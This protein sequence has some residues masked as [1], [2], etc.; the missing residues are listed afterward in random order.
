MPDATPPRSIGTPGRLLLWGGRVVGSDGEPEP[1]DIFIE[2]GHIAAMGEEVEAPES[3]SVDC[4]RCLIVPA[5]TDLH[6]HL[7]EPGQ[8][9]K[10]TVETGCLAAQ[11][12]GVGALVCMPNT[13]P[14]LA[15]P[16]DVEFVLERAAQ[17]G[18]GVHVMV[19]GSVL[20]YRGAAE[21]SDLAALARTGCV[22]LS[23]DG[24][25]LQDRGLA[26]EALAGCAEVGLPFFAHCED[27]TLSAAAG[28]LDTATGTE[29]HLTAGCRAEV[30][31]VERNIELADEAGARL[32]ILH[33]S[34]AESV[35]LLRQA[36]ADGIRVTAEA[37][38]HHFTL[39]GEVLLEQG[40]LAKMSPPLRR[41]RDV[42]AVIQGLL[43]GTIDAIASDHAPHTADEK[44]RGLEAA[45]AGI[46]GLETMAA[47]AHTAL[48][49]RYDLGLDEFLRLLLRAPAALVGATVPPLEVGA[50]ARLAVFRPGEWTIGEDWFLG[51]GRNTPFI[52][53]PV[54]LRPW[55]TVLEHAMF[56]ATFVSPH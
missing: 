11:A 29:E 27:E 52:G 33:I 46:V 56:S 18:R 14:L 8:T 53:Y 36:K 17:F 51:K 9:H 21:L 2:D 22:A 34:V 19:A 41:R 49:D 23:D 38:P 55:V 12:G 13:E 7:R 30:V 26:R 40:S 16:E 31:A 24:F 42:R 4:R 25:S 10:E 39:T 45:P 50:P 6:V 28:V 3:A 32:H 47:L 20:P 37:C 48:C 35:E 54:A 5:L 43:D 1:A 44:A 15:R